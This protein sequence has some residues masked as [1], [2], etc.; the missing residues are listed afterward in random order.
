MFWGLGFR[1]FGLRAACKIRD[2]CDS[3]VDLLALRVA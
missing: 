2:D 1:G 3:N